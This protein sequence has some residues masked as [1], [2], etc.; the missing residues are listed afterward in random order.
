MT[1][2][3]KFEIAADR[4]AHEVAT[5]IRQLGYEPVWKD[6]DMALTD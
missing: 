2:N 5:L 3:G 1:A 4:S 6:W